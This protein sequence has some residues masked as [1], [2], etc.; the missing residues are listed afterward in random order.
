MIFLRNKKNLNLCF[1]WHILRS[2]RFVA[3]V[4]FKK[5]IDK[6]LREVYY[7]PDHLWIGKIAIKELHKITSNLKKII[8]GRG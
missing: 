5:M 4:A 1:R 8:L 3:E 6:K 2:Y 7:Q